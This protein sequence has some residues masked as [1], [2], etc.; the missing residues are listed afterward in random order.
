MNFIR[1][2]AIK[3]LL[4]YKKRTLITAAALSIGIAV[5]ILMDSLVAGSM[6]ISEQNLI[7]YEMSHGRITTEEYWEDRD[8]FPLDQS[9]DDVKALMEMIRNRNGFEVVPRIS[10]IADLI[11]YQDP[12]PEDGNL[13]ILVT[14]LDPLEDSRV[15]ALDETVSRG[16]W[17]ESGQNE[18]VMGEWL[19]HDLGAD[20]GYP[21]T[22]VTRTRDGYYQ[23][24]D[25][26]VVGILDCPNPSINRTGFYI[27]LDT[28]DAA[29]EQ[30]GGVTELAVKLPS[31][32][33]V[34]EKTTNWINDFLPEGLVFHT[35]RD[36]SKDYISMSNG[37]RY[38]SV[39]IL[40]LV[41]IIAA[42]GVS[43]TMLMS[44]LER[45]RELGMMRSMGM[46]D[47]EIKKLFLNEAAGIGILGSL[48]GVVAGGLGNIPLVIKG[49]SL[50][51]AYDSLNFGYRISGT[52]WGTWNLS[53][54][55]FAVIT[56]WL[57]TVLVSRITIKKVL[58]LSIVDELRH[59]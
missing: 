38:S 34:N 31:D 1:S 3:N 10:F 40:F 29:L 24:M 19:A 46:H 2:L 39:I 30:R 55:A 44:V 52:M 35:W 53:T 27:P 11:V 33:D 36:L 58:N 51:G 41:F 7:R 4:R 22:L 5:Y 14:A 50:D 48:M 28:A 6:E 13:Q 12:F 26:V 57:I 21:M 45:T 23:T 15:F 17:L 59:Y 25:L 20:L 16:R 49:I 42:T 56:G 54:F 37:D 8:Y 18:V 9:M 47:K 32:K 43:N